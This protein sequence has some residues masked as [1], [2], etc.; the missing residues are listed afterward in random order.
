MLVAALAIITLIAYWAFTSTY[1]PLAI[2]SSATGGPDDETV[3]DVDGSVEAYRYVEGGYVTV[4]IWL[5][6]SGPMGVTITGVALSPRVS[7]SMLKLA[8]VRMA[9]PYPN[10]AKLAGSAPFHSFSLGRGDHP[11]GIMLRYRIGHCQDFDVGTSTGVFFVDVQYRVLGVSRHAL[12]ELPTGLWVTAP[13]DA[14]CP[15]RA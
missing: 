3:H 12:V 1:Q 8:E 2:G 7:V 11:P 5:D 9:A 6:N 10:P 4:V 13:P 14:A 15:A